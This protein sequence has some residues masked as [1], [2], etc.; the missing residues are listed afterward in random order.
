MVITFQI[1]F[2]LLLLCNTG[3]LCIPD[4]T[5]YNNEINHINHIFIISEVLSI[6]Q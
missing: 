6:N 2:P 1:Q 5:E 4:N 3:Y